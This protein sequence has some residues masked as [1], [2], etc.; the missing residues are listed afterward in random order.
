MHAAQ[1]AVDIIRQGD[2]LGFFQLFGRNGLDIRRYFSCGNLA[3]LQWCNADNVYD[4][5]IQRLI[6]GR[7]GTGR[8]QSNYPPYTVPN[9]D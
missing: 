7:Y 1:I 4:T 5:Q 2:A 3:A 6:L 9:P 8:R